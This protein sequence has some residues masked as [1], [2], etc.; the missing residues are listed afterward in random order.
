MFSINGQVF[1][2]IHVVHGNGEV[3]RITN[4]SGSRAY[5]LQL[6]DNAGK[7]LPVQVLAIDGVSLDSSA[8]ASVV[9]ARLQGRLKLASCGDPSN[10]SA[11]CASSVKMYPSSRVEI[12]VSSRQAE[13]TYS[14]TL[15]SQ[16]VVTGEDADLWP[17]SKLATVT[18]RGGKNGAGVFDTVTTFGANGAQVGILS[19][20]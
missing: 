4:T 14:A 10:R 12:W 17:A 1:H 7:A 8:P 13:K 15:V 16:M 18:F 6:I 11:V 9:A 3:W 19:A 20:P 5:D 2:P